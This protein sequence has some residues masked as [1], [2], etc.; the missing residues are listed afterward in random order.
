[1]LWIRWMSRAAMIALLCGRLPRCYFHRRAAGVCERRPLVNGLVLREGIISGVARETI[2]FLRPGLGH[3]GIR[4]RIMTDSQPA[5][6]SRS[7]TPDGPPEL[8]GILNLYKP[9]GKSS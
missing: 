7:S 9:V 3:R 1:M 8:S 6:A 4:R 2:A 5:P